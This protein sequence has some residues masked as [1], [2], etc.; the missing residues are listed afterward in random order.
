M[1]YILVFLM[2]FIPSICEA[3]NYSQDANCKGYWPMED[4]GNETDEN[5][6]TDITET[7]GTI[8]QDADAQFGTYSRQV[9]DGDTEYFTHG[10][11]NET[12]I[13]GADQDISFIVSYK[14][15]NTSDGFLKLIDKTIYWFAMLNDVMWVN[16][17]GG[18]GGDTAIGATDVI[19]QAWHNLAGV[20]NDTDIRAYL[21]GSLDSNGASNPKAHSSGINDDAGGFAVGADV[22]P[23][24][25]SDG[26]IDEVAIFDRELTSV[27]VSDI[28]TNGIV[29]AAPSSSIKTINGLA[30]ASVKTIDG[31][32]IASVKTWNGLE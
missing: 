24:A 30:K 2:V 8:P 27:E 11:G 13:S 15:Q 10:D 23:S 12:D 4:S 5:A 17:Y 18:S 3:T 9:E 31:L 22:S 19:D 21:D 28:N 26:L 7:S 20:Y 29:G 1:K 16:L 6:G 25:Y 32:A 14:S